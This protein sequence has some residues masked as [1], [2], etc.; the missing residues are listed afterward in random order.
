MTSAVP[1]GDRPCPRCGQL[2][3]EGQAACPACSAPRGFL[4]SLEQEALVLVSLALLAVLFLIT[5]FVTGRYHASQ[6]ALGGQWYQKGEAAMTANQP[7]KAVDAFHTALIYARDNQAYQLAL[8]EALI[9]AHRMAE[10]ESYLESL[11]SQQ[12]G[13]GMVNLD[14][15]RLAAYRSDVPEALRYYHDAIFGVWNGDAIRQR[16][17]TRIELCQFLLSHGENTEAESELIALQADLPRDAAI[18][19]K[20]AEMLLQVNDNQHALKEF[21]ATLKLNP[22]LE[23]A[24]AGAGSAAFQMADYSSARRY[25]QQAVAMNLEDSQAARQLEISKLVL[26]LDPFARRLSERQRSLRTVAAFNQALVRLR[27][28]AQAQ[29]VNLEEQ[30]AAAGTLQK[31]YASAENARSKVNEKS[32][33]HDPA[34][35]ASL[36]D[37]ISQME[38]STQQICGAGKPADQALLLISH[39]R[40]TAE[41]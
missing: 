37:V 36:M 40:G 38:S 18:H 26:S 11:W 21:R 3:P 20:V 10:A 28:C 34:T 6:A 39:M 1:E 32:L 25:L 13:S 17:E 9:S 31:A 19:A 12:P 23:N 35:V 33:L 27:Q 2:I 15:A 30:P 16:R 41:K 24:W 7:Q 29:G 4:W 8:V 5:G 14:L 22:R